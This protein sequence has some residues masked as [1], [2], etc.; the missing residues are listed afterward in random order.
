MVTEVQQ[1]TAGNSEAASLPWILEEAQGV[2]RGATRGGQGGCGGESD[3]TWGTR[4]YEGH[5][6]R[7]LGFPGEG[8]IGQLKP[9]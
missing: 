3:G 9:N 5:G 8:Q 4:L 6:G 1:K 7:A 2:V